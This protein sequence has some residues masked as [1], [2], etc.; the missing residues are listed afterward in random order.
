MAV[1]AKWYGN[2]LVGQYGTTA[3]RRVD[4]VTDSVKVALCTATY[5]PNQDTHVFFSDITNELATAGGYTAGGAALGTKSVSYDSASNETRLIAAATSWTSAS[6]TARYA[7]IYVD[8]AGAASTDPLMGWV[9]FGG[10]ETV[11]SGTFTI[12]WDATNGV[13]K[14]AAA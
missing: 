13:L 1:S 11:A 9:D 12:N 7:I 5:T 6:F 8:T 3:A 4:W 2:A 14:L 10:D